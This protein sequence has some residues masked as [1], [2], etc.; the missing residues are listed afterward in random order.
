MLGLA[1]SNDP[2]SHTG[3]SVATGRASHIEQAE[4]DDP[5]KNRYSGTPGWAWNRQLLFWHD[6]SQWAK[7]SLLSSFIDHTQRR[8][9]V[10]R[11]PLDE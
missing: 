2:E 6:S 1:W 3:S 7:A 8:T 5:G 11:T 9:T 4:G 10:S